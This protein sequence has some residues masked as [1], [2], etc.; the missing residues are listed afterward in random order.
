MKK[1]GDILKE[2]GFRPDASEAVKEAF[3]RH[4]IKAATGIEVLPCP[5]ER[6]QKPRPQQLAFDFSEGQAAPDQ[7]S[8]QTLKKSS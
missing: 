8:G 1:A 3:I 7:T 6:R 2:M 5:E 4:L